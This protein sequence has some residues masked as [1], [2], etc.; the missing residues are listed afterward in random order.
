VEEDGLVGS[1]EE[2]DGSEE[3]EEGSECDLSALEDTLS[4][5]NDALNTFPMALGQLE[6]PAVPVFLRFWA[7]LHSL[8]DQFPN[9][10]WSQT[11]PPTM[12]SEFNFVEDWLHYLTRYRTASEK[13][14]STVERGRKYLEGH[15]P[16]LGRVMFQVEG[17]SVV[18][19]KVSCSSSYSGE[20]GREHKINLKLVLH[21]KEIGAR[22]SCKNGL[23]A[24]CAHIA[25]VFLRIR[26][27][28]SG[29]EEQLPTKRR[30]STAEAHNFFRTL[31][32]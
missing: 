27:M 7:T 5:L 20:A 14:K 28:V 2:E 21:S 19:V 23:S 24:K 4:Q 8:S 18:L 22:C 1:E 31:R 17:L 6:P 16:R 3:S 25:A 26:K 30:G 29:V 13:R 9:T 15:F 12:L 10:G 11:P 32:N